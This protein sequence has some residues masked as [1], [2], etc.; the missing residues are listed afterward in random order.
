MLSMFKRN[1]A[2]RVNRKTQPLSKSTLYGVANSIAFVSASLLLSVSTPMS[3]FAAQRVVVNEAH[4][5]VDDQSQRTQQAALKKALQ[6][7]LVKMSGSTSVLDNARCKGRLA[8]P[9]VFASLLSL[10]F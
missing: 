10:Q 1:A 5:E 9:S 4:I 8:R 3:A 2:L 6:Q 7:V